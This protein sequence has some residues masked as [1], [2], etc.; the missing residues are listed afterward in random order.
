MAQAQTVDVSRLLDER[1]ISGFNIR[2]VIFAFLIVLFDGYDI[3]AMGFAAPHL[4]RAWHITDEAAL[5]PVLGATLVGM[6]LGAPL[7]GY[8]GDRFGRKKA[9]ILSL[10]IFGGFT[11][12]C[13]FATSLSQ[14]VYLRLL[15][16]I[17][18][19]GMM[20]N[21]I[22]LTA[23][24]AP[25]R[26]RATMI[27]V[28]FTGVS[29]GGGLPGAVAARLVPHYGWPVLFVV[30]GIVPI[31]VAII[32]AVGMPESIKHLVVKGNRRAEVV[33][34]L[35]SLRLGRSFPPDAQF[36]IRD[37]KQRAGFSPKHLFSD[38]LGLIT[39]LL[40][41]LFV[42]NLMGY[43]FLMS[44]TP[45]LLGSAHI[46]LDKAAIAVAL[47]QFGGAVGGWVLCRPMDT[48]GLMPITVLFALAVPAVV[49]IG[50]LGTISE[51]LLMIIE[52]VAGF[53]VLGLQFGLNAVSAMIYPTSFR[54]NG[55]GWAL[56]VGRVGAIVGPVLGGV[57]ITMFPVRQ[58]YVLA[59]I[60]F[61][62]GTVA[63]FILARLYRERFQ[64]HG[65]A[66]RDHLE[67]AEPSAT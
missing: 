12:I 44:W 13:A 1:G 6:L 45:V 24:F 56:G 23:E 43:F 54:S 62:V 46:P 33:R 36:V 59:A 65:M 40:W 32:C 10:L 20:P 50:Y 7:L 52:F 9:I 11:W 34:L 66:Q 64:G 14:L 60:P 35:T 37:E 3:T 31:V 5:G 29:F 67:S 8:V 39:P 18:L 41:L 19:G 2:L 30:G 4:I 16:G 15:A 17:G 22:A 25:R 21:I 51:P 63:C 55:S 28:M 47:F 42:V 57:L 61:L 49:L 26:Y 38:G 27:I 58:L 48:K 53:C